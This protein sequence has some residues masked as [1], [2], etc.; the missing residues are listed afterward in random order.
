MDTNEHV[1]QEDPRL[2]S[3]DARTTLEGAHYFFLG[4]GLLQ[5]AV[6]ICRGSEGTPVGVLVMDPALFG[7][8]QDCLNFDSQSGIRTSALRLYCNGQEQNTRRE[9]IGS[10][11]ESQS[12]MPMVR[13]QWQSELLRIR[14]EFFC[15]HL[16]QPW[17]L[18]I[19]TIAAQEGR[20]LSIRIETGLPGRQVANELL[21][22]AGSTETIAYRYK[23][24]GD[25]VEIET[26]Q[27]L[28]PTHATLDYWQ[29]TTAFHSNS[30]WLNHLYRSAAAQIGSNMADNGRLDASIWQYNLE[31]V[32]DQSFIAMGLVLCGQ[33]ERART[34]LERLLTT[35][36]SPEGDTI[37]SGR[38]RPAEEVELDQ[39]GELLAA[40]KLYSDWSGDLSLARDHWPILERVADFPFRPEFLDQESGMLHN[41]REYWERSAMHGL[42]EGFELAYQMWVSR[43]LRLAAELAQRLQQQDTA[44][45]WLERA[46]QL[47]TAYLYHSVYRLVEKERLVKRKD[48]SGQVQQK[49]LSPVVDAI[50]PGMPLAQSIPHPLNPDSSA[51]LLIA[52]EEIEAKDSIATAT[53]ADLELLWNQRWQTGGYGR[54]HVD[55]EPD[56]PGP[57]PFASLFIARA[58]CQA[59]NSSA[60]WRVLHWLQGLPGAESGAFFE[61]YGQRPIPPCPQIGFTPWS[62]AEILLLL[63]YQILGVRVNNDSVRI[64]P[65]LLDGIDRIHCDLL[66]NS[67]R[68][69]LTVERSSPGNAKINVE[70][71]P[72]KPIER[73]LE[74]PKPDKNV[75]VV[76]GI[77]P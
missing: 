7:R 43:G 75:R 58:H 62:Y 45:R 46:D 56:S 4:N 14:E 13:V 21:L 12:R 67:N 74:I 65:H 8:K 32:R 6:Q 38:R 18:R 30:E 35:A 54:Y 26:T 27:E 3:P 68:L 24:C 2:G 36:V 61:F 51:A 71:S 70:G 59:D 39:N 33:H 52:W 47:K 42:A 72:F 17:L 63:V 11:W 44:R 60:V 34:L 73:G 1:Y 22:A 40:V 69:D 5:A 20:D 25:Q 19:V 76:L 53:L 23:R 55:S 15:P 29:K 28:E 66:L 41:R 49:L 77:T 16:E 31:W 9:T 57:W 48:L 64:C 37:D 50:P 10:T